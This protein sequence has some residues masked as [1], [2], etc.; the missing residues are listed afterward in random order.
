MAIWKPGGLPY[1]TYVA[2]LNADVDPAEPVVTV[3][4][5][6]L[7]G[8]IAWSYVAPGVYMGVL[9]GAFPLAQTVAFGAGIGQSTIGE[10]IFTYPS[11]ADPNTVYYVAN[12]IVVGGGENLNGVLNGYMEIRVYSA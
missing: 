1:K 3:L 11:V 2:I 8:P 12:V 6:T 7:G 4:E 9:A 10:G 5:N